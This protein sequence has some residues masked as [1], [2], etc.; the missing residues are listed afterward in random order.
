MTEHATPKRR[1]PR[2]VG[3]IFLLL[4]SLALATAGIEVALRVAH[5]RPSLSSAWILGNRERPT[6]EDVVTIDRGFL[7]EDFY[8]PFQDPSPAKLLVTLGDSFTTSFPVGNTDRYP[9]VLERVLATHSFDARVMNVGM[10]DSG[11]DQQLKLFTK[12]VL[13][14]VRPDIVVWQFYPN[15]TYE[16]AIKA[17]YTV[18]NDDSLVPINAKHNWL[19]R[20]QRFFDAVPLPM[21]IKKNSYLF[22][23]I[24]RQ[25][26][27]GLEAQVPPGKDKLEWGRHKIELEIGRM[28]QLAAQNGFRVYYTLVAPESDYKNDVPPGSAGAAEFMEYQKLLAIVEKEPTFINGRFGTANLEEM[29][30]GT[31]LFAD[32]T[33]DPSP[34]GSRHLNEAGYRFLAHRIANRV[35][36]DNGLSPIPAEPLSVAPGPIR[37]QIGD[38]SARRFLR[39]GWQ[40][41]DPGAN[42]P[43]VWSEGLQSV[44]DIPLPKGSDVRMDFECR[45]LSYPRSPP[46][47]LSVALNGKM[48]QQLTLSPS[49][50]KYSVILPMAAFRDWPDRIEMTYAYSQRPMDVIDGSTDSR[51]LAVVW[52]SIEFT[53]V[54]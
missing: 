3:R 34:Y 30:S 46:Q 25:Y 28:N 29:N 40:Q 2:L 39:R 27:R 19:Y 6:D 21:G 16:N 53:P 49:R 50:T 12:Y 43:Y 11:P 44:L 45:P 9:R 41:D 48:I 13:P 47:T 1:S 15:D 37:V 51:A 42:P 20:R 23:L 10:G 36:R 33:R 54:R 52:Y 24:L 22:N 5:Y 32:G 17:L 8:R 31:D 4:M 14:R 18:G 26:E 7:A 35:L 38:A